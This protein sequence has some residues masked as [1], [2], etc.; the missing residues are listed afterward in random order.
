MFKKIITL[1]TPHD[2]RFLI[3]L[4]IFS[5]VI[6]LIETFAVSII[7]PFISIA[8]DFTLI[9][10]NIYYKKIYHFFDLSSPVNF[11]VMFG[12]LLFIFYIFRSFINIFYFYMLSK[13]S[14]GRYFSI[15]KRLFESYLHF[16]N[17][18]FNSMNTAH[19][20]KMVVNE[21]SYST[22]VISSLLFMISE[23]FVIIFIYSIL[24]Y[25]DWQSTLF[26]SLVLVVVVGLILR[27]ITQLVNIKGKEREFHQRSVYDILSSSFGNFKVIK[28]FA[29]EKE[30]VDR[31]S[32]VS[33]KFV[34]TNIV[35]ETSSHVPRLV[36]D[37]LGF[38]SLSFI[39]A[40]LVWKYDANISSF[41]PV[42]SLYILALYRLL[43]SLHRI[44]VRYNKIMFYKKSVE[45]IHNELRYENEKF[46]NE[47]VTFEDE[48]LLEN[49][50]FDYDGGV[51]ILSDI[52]LRIEKGQSI[53]IMGESGS[54]KSTLVDIIIGLNNPSKGEVL[55]DGKRLSFKNIISWRKQIGYIPQAIYLFDGNVGD[56]IVFGREYDEDQ[57]ISVLQK[58]KLW[59]TFKD[60]DGLKTEVG[61][62][63]KLLSGGQKQRVAIARA[64]YSSPDI[65]VLDEATSALDSTIEDT[66]MNEIYTICENKTLL[67]ISHNKDILYGCD[68][69]IV[70]AESKVNILN[71]KENTW[72]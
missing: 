53:G 3:G 62:G 51:S 6:S 29:N 54:G 4:I 66:I 69:V 58:V 17:Q 7:M 34:H 46:G 55:V 20:I 64:L 37:A 13:F 71:K 16:N 30:V 57:L 10:T 15:S 5:I 65:L 31:F 18:K 23:I 24:L 61:E 14:E 8:S 48:I 60:K 2:K 70:I 49:V 36:L 38:A 68:R 44:I 12:F 32:D 45:L 52:N 50:T 28:L 33:R 26:L 19:L 56:N 67:I 27:K 1:L 9:E 42:L 11:V 39:V 25:V 41:M 59:D 35:F 43:P 40:F 22:Q 47:E 72:M 63:G 21:A